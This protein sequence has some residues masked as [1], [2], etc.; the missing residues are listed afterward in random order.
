MLF[1]L[2]RTEHGGDAEEHGIAGHPLYGGDKLPVFTSLES[3]AGGL[4]SC[5]SSLQDSVYIGFER[6]RRDPP[7]VREAECRSLR[8][9]L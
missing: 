7:Q 9:V 5:A 2:M 6:H 4:K 1:Y 3:L 8:R